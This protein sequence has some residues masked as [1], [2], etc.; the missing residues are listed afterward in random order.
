VTNPWPSRRRV[1]N[2]TSGTASVRSENGL[3][4]ILASMQR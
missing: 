2:L 1:R 3:K 4:K